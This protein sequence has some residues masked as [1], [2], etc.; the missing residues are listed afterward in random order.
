MAVATIGTEVETKGDGA[1]AETAAVFRVEMMIET[2]DVTTIV[3]EDVAAMMIATVAAEAS[4]A[5]C[6][7]TVAAAS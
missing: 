6:T 3:T 4:T 5:I 7:M 1:A 2:E